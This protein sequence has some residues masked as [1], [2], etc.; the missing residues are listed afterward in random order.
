MRQW[1]RFRKTRES[2]Q[3]GKE[4]FNLSDKKL[5]EIGLLAPFKFNLYELVL[6]TL[7]AQI[8]FKIFD[9]FCPWSQKAEEIELKTV[10][11][12]TMAR[13][14]ARLI[15]GFYFLLTP[16][17]PPLILFWSAWIVSRASIRD[18]D[19]TQLRLWR[20][21]RAYYF[22]NGAHGLMPQTL[23]SLGFIFR[24]RSQEYEVLEPLWTFLVIRSLLFFSLF[25]Q[26]YVIYFKIPNL[27]FQLNGYSKKE[28]RLTRHRQ[29]QLNP[30][31]YKKYVLQVFG[32]NATLSF[33]AK[34]ALP[35]L[36][37]VAAGLIAFVEV[38]LR[39]RLGMLR[40]QN[41]GWATH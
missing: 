6:A 20:S 12:K 36:L 40:Q 25:Y 11:G 37:A 16:L 7:T 28:F 13:D 26:A 8:A 31:P 9:F 10:F 15:D 17:L 5:D 34:Y 30:P 35:V 32:W 14:A 18:E 24:S 38:W 3:R 22:Y 41:T 1:K 4:L 23:M 39:S 2:I 21:K 33:I 19:L 27:L 29:R